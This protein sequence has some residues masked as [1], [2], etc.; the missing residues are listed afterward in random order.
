MCDTIAENEVPA[1]CLKGTAIRYEAVYRFPRID[2]PA[3]KCQALTPPAGGA[4]RCSRI[5]FLIALL[6]L[7]A[8]ALDA[9]AQLPDETVHITPRV[10]PEKASPEATVDPALKTHTKPI[11]VDVNLVLV[12]VTITDPMNRLVTGLEKDNF[13]IYEGSKLEEI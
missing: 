11:Q 1:A 7:C 10:K 13:L 4:P 5:S 8:W 2:W 6:V 12:N 9:R 3:R